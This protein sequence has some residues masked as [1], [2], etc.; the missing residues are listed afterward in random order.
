MYLYVY[1][2]VSIQ[3]LVEKGKE[4]EKKHDELVGIYV[5]MCMI[6]NLLH[7]YSTLSNSFPQTPSGTPT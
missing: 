6:M 1:V 5:C 2:Y 4:E 7:R 3:P